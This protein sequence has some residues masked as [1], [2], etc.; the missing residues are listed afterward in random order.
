MRPRILRA[1]AARRHPGRETVPRPGVGERAARW[2]CWGSL[3]FCLLVLALGCSRTPR[4]AEHAEVS[5]K[6]LYKGQPLPGGRVTFVS[7][8]GTF[9]STG[10]IDE[11]GDYTIKAPVGEVKISVDNRMLSALG[12][13]AGALPRGAGRRPQEGGGEPNPVKGTY[14]PIPTKYYTPDTSGLTYTV[15]KGPQTHNIELR[16]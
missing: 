14:K 2:A 11:K 15:Q 1:W 12:A 16:D 6:V 3:L 9:A 5:G 7:A 4:S 13:K 8:Q 10:N